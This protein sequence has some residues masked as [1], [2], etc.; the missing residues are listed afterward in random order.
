MYNYVSYVTSV[1]QSAQL[2]FHTHTKTHT[3]THKDCTSVLRLFSGI[4]VW[5]TMIGNLNTDM[6]LYIIKANVTQ[7][8]FAKSRPDVDHLQ[9]RNTSR[10][11]LCLIDYCTLLIWI[12]YRLPL[13]PPRLFPSNVSM[14]PSNLI[15]NMNTVN[16][17]VLQIKTFI[18]ISVTILKYFS[19]LFFLST[20]GKRTYLATVVGS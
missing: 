19:Y 11:K 12:T 15:T 7:V 8:H 2:N 3:H 9:G 10:I 17:T 5:N 6:L 4:N 1:T 20:R 16:V 13:T 14:I 18:E